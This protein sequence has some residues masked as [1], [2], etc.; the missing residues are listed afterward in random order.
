MVNSNGRMDWGGNGSATDVTLERVS[1]GVLRVGAGHAFRTGLAVTGSRPSA[2]SVG[3]GSQF[4]DTTL[5]RPI[6]STGSA[7][8]GADGAAA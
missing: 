6:W 2:S 5:N 8:V 7:W 1:A 4:F 3:Q